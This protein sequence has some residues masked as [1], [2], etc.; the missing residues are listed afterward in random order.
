ME[1]LRKNNDPWENRFDEL[2]FDPKNN[3]VER[4]WVIKEFIL[5]ERK[6]AVMDVLMRITRMP[7]L[8]VK[9]DAQENALSNIRKWYIK[10]CIPKILKDYQM[11]SWVPNKNY[12]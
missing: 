10:E 1:E 7:L 8:N 6:N 2:Y 11:S 5:E 12:L 4:L 9:N 3:E